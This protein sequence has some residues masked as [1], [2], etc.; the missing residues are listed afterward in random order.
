MAMT[1]EEKR[2]RARE[3]YAKNKKAP[4]KPPRTN[5]GGR[6]YPVAK[7]GPGRKTIYATPNERRLARN[8]LA[9]AKRDEAKRLAQLILVEGA[10]PPKP[11]NMAE[12]RRVISRNKPK[13]LAITYVPPAAPA[14]KKAGR[15]R[16]YANDEERKQAKREASRRYREKM[17]VVLGK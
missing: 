16:L 9:K 14:K 8:A 10:A 13:R 12:K 2:R 3:R 4:A 1:L 7:T 6:L 17:K 11:K 5:K 15:P